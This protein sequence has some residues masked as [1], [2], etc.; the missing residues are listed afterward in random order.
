MVS[1][2]ISCEKNWNCVNWPCDDCGC[3]MRK[4]SWAIVDFFLQATEYLHSAIKRWERQRD[5]K[6]IIKILN[7]FWTLPALL[8]LN[9]L[10]SNVVLNESCKMCS[11]FHFAR[12]LFCQLSNRT[13]KKNKFRCRRNTFFLFLFFSRDLPMVLPV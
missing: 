9:A 3:R 8:D 5:R 10:N 12:I 13:K 7:D 1:I 6:K 11:I 4:K 2:K